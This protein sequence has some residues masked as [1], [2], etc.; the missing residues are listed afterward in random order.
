M[1]LEDSPSLSE[2]KDGIP[3]HP[4]DPNARRKRFRIALFVSLSIVLMMAAI[5]FLKSPAANI[6][7]GQGAVQGYVVDE[8]NQPF[9]GHIFI[10]GTELDIKT[11]SNGYF[12]ME[13][14]PAGEQIL[15]AADEEFADEF[16]ITVIA[17]QTVDIGQIQFVSL[18]MP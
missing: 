8:I 13:N 12:L 4:V 10:L 5:L 1:K 17:G 11:S 14:V 15:I 16:P 2:F 7:A 6:L 18:A 3:E 9:Q